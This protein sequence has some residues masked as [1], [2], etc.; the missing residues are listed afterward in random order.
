VWVGF[1][2]CT[3]LLHEQNII[4][5]QLMRALYSLS[6]FFFGIALR[7][8]APFHTKARLL[9]RG[10]KNLFEDVANKFKTNSQP[11]AWFHCASLGE[12]EQGRP[13]MEEFKKRN[14]GYKILLTFFSSS[15]YE[16]RKNYAG[17]DVVCYLPADTKANAKRFVEIVNP[18]VI[19][20]VKYEFW[21]NFLAEF[22][23]KNISHFLVS[24]I[25]REDQ[26]FFK[27][28]GGIFRE[29]LKG[30]SFIFTQEK[31]SLYLLHSIGIT[32]AEVAGDT[33]FDRVAEIAAG[34]KEIPVAKS[35]AGAERKVLV[36]GST[37]P[38]DEENLFPIISPLLKKDWKL[39]IAPHELGEAHLASIEK[40]LQAA[41]IS[42]T[43][44]IRYSKADE[45][46]AA[47]TKVLLI[48]NIGMLSSLYAY[49]KIAYIGGGFG[50][51]IHNVLEA[52]VYGIP[53]VFGPR[54]EKFNEAKGLISAG[55]GFGVQSEEELKGALSE[56]MTDEK[57]RAAAGNIAGKFVS[58]NTGATKIILE[59]TTA[60]LNR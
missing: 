24:A 31:K 4:I 35:F 40:G 16:V 43:E 37:W 33:R 29:A 41:G 6:I 28:H 34:A 11:V 39:L 42:S 48:D 55:G 38:A 32:N 56:L 2:R 25:F 21:L 54:F 27:S 53:V 10:R 18:S 19:F 36:A 52:A 20:F 9:V 47:N 17:A 59:K 1:F 30:F 7:L 23:K 58:E 57:K 12:F 8:A 60:F 5:N 51:S 46:T 50:K 49:G 22:R 44:I 3:K 26:I 13:L 14:T 45:I 15:G